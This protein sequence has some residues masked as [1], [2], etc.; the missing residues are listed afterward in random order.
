MTDNDN[1]IIVLTLAASHAN[2]MDRTAD[3]DYLVSARHTNTVYKIFQDNATIAWRLGGKYSNFKQDFNF[4]SQHDVRVVHETSTTMLLTIMD[5]AS[6]DKGR[7]KDTAVASSGKLVAL[8]T[9]QRPMTAKANHIP[10]L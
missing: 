1:M 2:S 6:D 4:S 3:G 5:N 9:S 10:S 7:Q 8:D